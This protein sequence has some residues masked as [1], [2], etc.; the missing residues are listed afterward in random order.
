MVFKMFGAI[1]LSGGIFIAAAISP[2]LAEEDAAPKTVLFN[3]KI[4]A[5]M[6]DTVHVEGQ[7]TGEG[8]GYKV[9]RYAMTCYRDRKE[10][11]L[12]HVDTQGLQAFSIGPPLFFNVLKWDKDLIVADLPGVRMPSGSPCGGNPGGTTWYIHRDTQITVI[13]ENFC[14]LTTGERGFHEWTVEDDPFWRKLTGTKQPAQPP[15]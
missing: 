14:A 13:Q 7:V 2:T 4:F 11:I 1:V 9:N 12:T 8:I 10:C 15:R 6:G 3:R 5:D